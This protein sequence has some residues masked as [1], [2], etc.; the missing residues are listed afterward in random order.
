ME[1]IENVEVIDVGT[2]GIAIAKHNGMVVFL[3][4]AVTGDIVDVK[5]LK[6]KK[7]YV[8][9][10]I[11]KIHKAGE[12]RTLPFC[13][14]YGICGGCKWQHITYEGQLF[15]KQKQ[16]N[17]A[18]N[19]VARL[20]PKVVLPIIP[21]PATIEYRNKMEYAFTNSSWLNDFNENKYTDKKPGLGFHIAGMFKQIINIQKCYLQNDF[22]NKLRNTIR[23][24]AVKEKMS[25]YNIKEH[26][27]FLRNIIIRNT[28]INEWMLIVV[29]GYENIKLRES[30]LEKIK[31]EFPELN[32][33]MYVIN[34]KKNDTISD[35]PVYLYSGYSYIT[36]KM[37]NLKLKTGPVSFYQTNSLQAENLYSVIKEFASL[38]GKETV[39]DLYTG[40]GSIANFISPNA[41]KIIGID[42][43]ESA[44]ADAS[45]NSKNNNINNTIFYSGDL[46]KIFTSDFININGI[47]DVIIT[48]PPRSG[49]HPKVVEEILKIMP[50]KI[51]YVSCNPATQARDIAMLAKNY[52]IIKMQAVDMFP[53][54][55]HI[56]NVVLLIRN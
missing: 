49:M 1:I 30:L 53:H 40:T 6:K 31:A 5:I 37:H 55:S 52:E 27:G 2:D 4:Y 8:E 16:I 21:S 38:S 7:N 43:I 10:K 56:E 33:L 42:N 48:D 18:F 34:T 24:I 28:T 36:E 19:R 25:F 35:L 12:T 54:T 14:H 51:V 20:S 17:D 44:I 45:E 9:G 47:P 3:K 32:S 22:A 26:T 39:Y 50:Q 29:F 11:E 41:Y 46:A 15:Y 13:S 23:D